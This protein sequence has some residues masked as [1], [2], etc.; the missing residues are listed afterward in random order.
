MA[1]PGP[2]ARFRVVD[3]TDM[4]GALCARM[5]ADLGADVVRFEG[6]LSPQ[7]ARTPEHLYRNANKRGVSADL[8]TATG[9]EGL[10]ALC[11]QADVLVENFGPTRAA[12]LDLAPDAVRERHPQLVH[13]AL[14]D[15]G[16]SGPRSRWRLEPLPAIASSGALY[17]SGFPQLAP[18]WLPGHV[19][20]DCASVYGALGAV[21]ALMDRDRHGEGQS[22]DVST[23]ESSFAGLYPWG[24]PLEDFGRLSPLAPTNPSRGADGM[25]LVLPASDGHVRVVLGN[26]RHWQGFVQLAGNPEV[27]CGEEWNGMVHRLINQD[28]IRIV[29]QERLVDRTRQ[30]LSEQARELG[31]PLGAIHQ[32]HEFVEHEQTKTRGTFLNTG[33]P[34]VGEAPFIRP[35]VKLSATPATLR[36]PAPAPGD[37]AGFED[38]REHAPG[39]G[40]SPG[41]LLEGLRVIEFGVA[42]VIP[43]LVFMLSELG[44]E[45]VKIE[46]NAHLDVLRQS[47]DGDP[48]H[49]VTFYDEC[50][51]REGVLLDLTT[52][53]GRELAFELCAGADLVVEN[54]RGG[55]L[56]SLGLG[57]EDVRAKN[58]NVIYVASQGYGRGGPLDDMPSFGPLNSAFAGVH[59]LWN[60]PDA[61]YPCGSTMNHPDHIAGKMLGIAV[62]AAIDHRN[63]TGEGQHIELAQAEAAAYLMGEFYLLEALG[64]GA[65]VARGNRSDAAVPH[66]VYPAAGEDR[67]IAIVAPDDASWQRLEQACGFAPDPQLATLE[68]RLVRRDAIDAKLAEWT[69]ERSAVQA[70]ETLQAAGVSACAVMGPDDHRADEHLAARDAIVTLEHPEVGPCRHMRNPLRMSR[71]PLRTAGCAPLLGEHTEAVLTRLLG[72][73]RDEVAELVSKGVC[74]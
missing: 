51:G 36:H 43:E 13:V 67:W 33:F 52:P 69:R 10:E 17:Q 44:A 8:S 57:Y 35:A 48:N 29:A 71:T 19:A 27:I 2:L 15:F 25:Y 37:N 32:P 31:V 62:L 22:I 21:A 72:L 56:E 59:A 70:A 38:D 45:I 26:A 58:P 20:H 30:Q 47:I 24:M 46:S 40:E 39:T 64:H 12:E 14:S 41:L 28:V 55:V 1:S 63:R 5:L 61:P 73:S 6:G 54:N 18:C 11:A 53:R 9:R 65:P 3:L 7:A 16:S 4:R 74:N 49:A 68:A 66:D 34:E 23:Q 50:R 60:H 42:A